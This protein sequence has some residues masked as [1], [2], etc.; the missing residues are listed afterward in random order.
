MKEKRE[1]IKEMKERNVHPINMKQTKKS[2]QINGNTREKEINK[3]TGKTE[4]QKDKTCDKLKEE[5]SEK[6][7]I[8]KM[9]W[10]IEEKDG[11]WDGER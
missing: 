11:V 6:K 2:K 3:Q 7:N 1:K 4:K 10:Q 9:L 5:K 8:K